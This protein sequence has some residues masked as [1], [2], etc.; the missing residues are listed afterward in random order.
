[1]QKQYLVPLI[2]E[3]LSAATFISKVVA[4]RNQLDWAQTIDCCDLTIDSLM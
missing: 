3:W 1:M 2:S 4:Q